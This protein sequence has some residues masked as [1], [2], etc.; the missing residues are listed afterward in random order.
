M[1]HE[2]PCYDQSIEGGINMSD[3]EIEIFF[4]SD[5]ERSRQSGG[6]F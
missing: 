3:E 1:H 5:A 2:M 6:S 4:A